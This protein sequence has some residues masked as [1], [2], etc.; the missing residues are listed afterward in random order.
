MGRHNIVY[1][2]GT[3]KKPDISR[4]NPHVRDNWPG[5]VHGDIQRYRLL[6]ISGNTR[7]ENLKVT[8]LEGGNS[9]VCE[10]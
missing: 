2:P 5:N 10:L 6:T 1:N 3:L 4:V 7:Y 8:R 9:A